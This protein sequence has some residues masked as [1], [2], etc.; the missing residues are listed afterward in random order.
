MITIAA[1]LFAETLNRNKAFR[2]EL[3][4]AQT[5]K[6]R[7]RIANE[8]GFDIDETDRDAIRDALNIEEL[9]D[10]DLERVA[11]GVDGAPWGHEALPSTLPVAS[12][13]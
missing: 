5:P 12:I 8:A 6:E 9:C 11:R 2:D 13:I 10:E 1:H 7:L 4:A 3:A